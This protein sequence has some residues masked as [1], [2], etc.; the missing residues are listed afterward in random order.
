MK[1]SAPFTFTVFLALVTAVVCFGFDSSVLDDR[2]RLSLDEMVSR[3]D[4]LSDYTIHV[5]GH[6]DNIGSFEYNEKLSEKR[7]VAV[8]DY[9]ISKKIDS[10][11]IAIDFHGECEPVAANSS[12]ENCALNRRV[13]VTVT[14]EK[15]IAPVEPASV[16][17]PVQEVAEPVTQDVETPIPSAK[18]K[19]KKKKVR[20]RLVWTGWRTGFHWSTAGG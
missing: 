12:E 19:I 16:G 8:R 6:T 1:K 17:E 9:L 4:P 3:L 13:E 11:R 18:A 5:S 7:A 15:A 14:V 2:A 20:R 10:T